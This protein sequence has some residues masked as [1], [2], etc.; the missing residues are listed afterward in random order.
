MK[1]IHRDQHGFTLVE[2]SIVLIIFGLVMS[3]VMLGLKKYMRDLSVNRTME[4]ITETERA[5]FVFQLQLEK[6]PCPAD[7][8]LAPGDPMY[9]K[10]DCGNINLI[11]ATGRDVDGDGNGEQVLIGTVPFQTFLDPNDDGDTSDAVSENFVAKHGM[12]GWGNKLTYAV[13]TALT[14]AVPD[15]F[16]HEA[17]AIFIVD[18]NNT[19]LLNTPGIAHAV[20][21]SHGADSKGAWTEGGKY[22]DD[23]VDIVDADAVDKANGTTL[24]LDEIEN[25]DHEEPLVADAIFLKAIHNQN[26]NNYNDDY[27]RFIVSN[28]TNLWAYTNVLFFNNGTDD[29]DDDFQINQ[30]GNTNGGFI[31]IGEE[32][33][34]VQFHLLGDVQAY[35]IHAE[36]LCDEAGN[37]CMPSEIIAGEVADMKCPAGHVVTKIEKN[38]VF[39]ADAFADTPYTP[40]PPGEFLVGIS[41]VTGPICI[42][43]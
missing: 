14:D 37:D 21:I 8:T 35:E 1:Y 20:I 43:P 41:N 9:G 11:T 22:A 16:N 39:C 33:P 4:S 31:G 15:D 12:D 24:P 13:T 36:N 38:R 10:A 2:L 29:T 42:I 7:P 23:C 19:N 34:Q 5:L 3:S 18:E 40:C 27:V 25:C 28:V 30:V 6:Y 32:S 17:G 26:N